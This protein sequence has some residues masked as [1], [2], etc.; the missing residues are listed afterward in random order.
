[1][2][3]TG[4]RAATRPA[5][6]AENGSNPTNP[7]TRRQIVPR[8]LSVSCLAVALIAGA[9]LAATLPAPRVPH[10][11]K[12]DVPVGFAIDLKASEADVTKAV[13]YIIQDQIIHGTQVYARE[14]EL[15]DAEP[16][17]ASE[18][19]GPWNGPGKAYYKMRRG[20]LAPRHFKDSRDIGTITVR[21]IVVGVA[22]NRTH[23]QI[24]AVFIEDGGHRVHES[25]TTVETSEFAEIQGQILR[26][27]REERETAEAQARQQQVREA[28]ADAK[29]RAA[30]A[31][32]LQDADTSVNSLQMRA[33]ELE[34]DAEVRVIDRA[35]LKSAPFQRAATLLSVPANSDVLVEI[36]TPYWYGVET[37][38]GHRGWLRREQVEPLP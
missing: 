10:D 20:A 33:H 19:Y 35:D 12:S 8:V 25:D 2:L 11:K 17:T 18:Y 9:T 34:H 24:D 1:M 26:I 6:P 3:E 22:P 27:Q 31:A 37:T 14:D 15:T 7:S 23:L 5:S 32:R 16:A 28:Q 38:D 30:E 21:Y 29:E 13:Q 36:I 4:N